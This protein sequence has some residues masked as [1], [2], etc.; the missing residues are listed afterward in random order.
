MGDEQTAQHETKKG[1][2]APTK[3]KSKP[4]AE[5]ATVY[6]PVMEVLPV[7][8]TVPKRIKK[9]KPGKTNGKKANRPK[10]T[11]VGRR[12]NSAARDKQ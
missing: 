9:K 3:A 2:K 1:G 8:V 6:M 5:R 7:K 10:E 11:K 4:R 12:T